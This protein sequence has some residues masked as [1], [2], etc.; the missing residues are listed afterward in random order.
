MSNDDN[1]FSV[2]LKDQ[3]SCSYKMNNANLRKR[4]KI[5]T[6]FTI[7]HS[8]NISPSFKEQV[9]KELERRFRNKGILDSEKLKREENEWLKENPESN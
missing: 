6:L 7:K 4:T 5:T 9:I 3:E 8:K 2:N 1:E